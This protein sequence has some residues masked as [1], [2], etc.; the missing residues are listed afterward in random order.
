MSVPGSS[1]LPFYINLREGTEKV[2]D[3]PGKIQA[4]ILRRVAYG[5]VCD[6]NTVLFDK[7]FQ[8]HIIIIS[9]FQ[10]SAF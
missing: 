6:G 4:V 7:H 5:V 9:N 8:V 3:D 10:Y 2:Q 1:G